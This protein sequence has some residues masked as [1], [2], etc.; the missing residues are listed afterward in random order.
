MQIFFMNNNNVP[1]INLSDIE[2]AK[3]RNW[4]MTS[5]ALK[6]SVKVRDEVLLSFPILYYIILNF[7]IVACTKT[8]LP[9]NET[10]VRISVFHL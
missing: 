10:I 3:G 2:K 7:A 6:L 9:H 1:L 8:D 4:M 5:D